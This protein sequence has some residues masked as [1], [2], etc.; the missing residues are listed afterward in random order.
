MTSTNVPTIKCVAVGDG[1]VGK[2]SLLI[3]YSTNSFPTTYTPTVFDN[4]NALTMFNNKP[5]NLGLWDTAG[6][7]SMNHMRPLSYPQTVISKYSLTILIPILFKMSKWWPEI[8]AFDS[9]AK[10]I[11]VGLKLDLRDDVET[12]RKLQKEAKT[13]ITTKECEQ[14]SEEI[15]A[16]KYWE[17]SALTQKNVKPLFDE[18]VRI[19]LTNVTPNVKK[20]Q[21]SPCSIM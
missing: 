17:C 19:A 8:H 4:Y 3:S 20:P 11:L 7:D 16:I 6:Q 9:K 18:T 2:T 21:K 10:I 14:L 12:I 5:Y 1:S 13:P 15:G